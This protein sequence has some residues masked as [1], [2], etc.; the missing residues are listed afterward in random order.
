LITSRYRIGV[1][2]IEKLVVATLEGA[3]RAVEGIE[4]IIE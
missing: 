3:E 4:E 2:A 1:G